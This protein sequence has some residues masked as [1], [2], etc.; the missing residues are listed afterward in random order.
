MK[1]MKDVKLEN[2][3]L[4]KQRDAASLRL[5][6][7]ESEKNSHA[8]EKENIMMEMKLMKDKY[9]KSLLQYAEEIGVLKSQMTESATEKE[10]PIGKARS[11]IPSCVSAC[12][13]NA[14]LEKQISFDNYADGD[15]VYFGDKNEEVEKDEEEEEEEVCNYCQ[16]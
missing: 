5:R 7:G 1:K 6:A 10:E 13:P 8:V 2:G 11:T 14:D 15:S 4:V 12:A 9:E 3:S 16:G